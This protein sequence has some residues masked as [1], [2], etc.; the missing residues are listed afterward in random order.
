M[1]EFNAAFSAARPGC[2]A[3]I[4]HGA[5]GRLIFEIQEGAPMRVSARSSGGRVLLPE[6]PARYRPASDPKSDLPGQR[7]DVLEVELG[8]P[9]A[10]TTLRL[11]FA[12]E[13]KDPARFGDRLWI[14]VPDGAPA[15][16]VRI[17][18]EQGASY[19]E[20]VVGAWDDAVEDERAREGSWLRPYCIYSRKE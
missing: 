17:H 10:G 18:L 13:N 1:S 14:H 2:Y 16:S 9:G 8:T 4:W 11:M 3:G 20:A 5:D 15:S 12:V 6:K 19:L 7:L